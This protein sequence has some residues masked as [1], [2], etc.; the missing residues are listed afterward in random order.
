MSQSTRSESSQTAVRPQPVAPPLGPFDPPADYEF[1][2]ELS[3]PVPRPVPRETRYG[4]HAQKNRTA[5]F[6]LLWIGIFALALSPLP[7]VKECGKYFIPCEY[8]RWIG[9]G[10]VGLAAVMFVQGLVVIGPYRYIRDGIPLVAR[11]L[12]LVKQPSLFV[13]GAPTSYAVFARIE[14]IDPLSSVLQAVDVKSLDFGA[15][16]CAQLTTS[17]RVGDYVTAVYLPDQMPRSLRLY[18][19]LDLMPGIGLVSTTGEETGRDTWWKV[20]LTVLTAVGFFAV[21]F[22]NVIALGRYQP[23][24]LG[25]AAGVSAFAVG[26]VPAAILS[27]VGG[28]YSR[29]REVQR[30]LARNAQALAAGEPVEPESAGKRNWAIKVVLVFGAGLLG[31]MTSL[32]GAFSINALLD[33]SPA[34]NEP[35]QITD[36]IVTTHS[37]LF[38][39]YSLKYKL[40]TKAGTQTLMTTP[41]HLARF[42]GNAGV[43][44]IHAGRLGWPW[45]KTIEPAPAAPLR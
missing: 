36:M 33:N 1:E 34:R 14:F 11:V 29:R 39:E 8:L 25:A 16:Q 4:R 43:A 20:P 28:W 9:F 15:P 7:F 38:R 45:I 13:N 18:A 41:D 37:F 26:G 44:E 40:P 10:A 32:C 35:V 3:G 22:W 31:G 12:S 21:L 17:F 2:A 27:I 5:M 24:T 42:Q 19:L 23:L 30:R 6:A